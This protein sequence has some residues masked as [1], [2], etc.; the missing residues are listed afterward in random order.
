MICV[1]PSVHLIKTVT[2]ISRLCQFIFQ[3]NG[4]FPR[5]S[6]Y[7]YLISQLNFSSRPFSFSSLVQKVR[8]I[9]IHN[10][11]R[12]TSFSLLLL[13]V[14]FC[15]G[16]NESRRLLAFYQ[17]NRLEISAWEKLSHATKSSIR[18]PTLWGIREIVVNQAGRQQTLYS[19]R[20]ANPSGIVG[21]KTN[22]QPNPLVKKRKTF[23][24]SGAGQ[25][26]HPLL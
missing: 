7:S 17:L 22:V 9:C 1:T 6:F 4:L 8:I 21:S 26:T 2:C 23:S 18:K 15:C 5:T 16:G 19:K 11:S 24:D 10:K 14:R 25:L 3:D 13:S 12:S 20:S